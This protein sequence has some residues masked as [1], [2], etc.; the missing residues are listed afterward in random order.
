MRILSN[1]EVLQLLNKLKAKLTNNLSDNFISISLYGS[2]ARNEA[3]KNSD[4]DVL[5][6]VKNYDLETRYLVSSI[7]S[8]LELEFEDTCLSSILV[9]EKELTEK[10]FYNSS[11]I[12]SVLNE[13]IL[14]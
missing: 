7:A 1:D 4:I 12:K 2:Y 14:I 11:F 3:N 9:E 6:V 5:V 13:R 10:P 8:D